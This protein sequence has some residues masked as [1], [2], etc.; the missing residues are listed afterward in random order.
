MADQKKEEH[1]FPP[2][3][4]PICNFQNAEHYNFT[5]FSKK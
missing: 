5:I 4:S 2:R 3:K 1:P